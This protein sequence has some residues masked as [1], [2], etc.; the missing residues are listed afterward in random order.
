MSAPNFQLRGLNESKTT[1]RLKQ[2]N[3]ILIC[4]DIC[5]QYEVNLVLLHR[6]LLITEFIAGSSVLSFLSYP[7]HLILLSWT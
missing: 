6:I 2:L 4:N 7:M 1:E 3:Y 5:L